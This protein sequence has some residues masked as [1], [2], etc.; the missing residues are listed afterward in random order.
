MQVFFSWVFREYIK[1][2]IR[3]EITE[4]LSSICLKNLLSMRDCLLAKLI[5]IIYLSLASIFQWNRLIHHCYFDDIQLYLSLLYWF[6]WGQ[7][8][9][10]GV[11][12]FTKCLW[13]NIPWMELLSIDFI[14]SS[15]IAPCVIYSHLLGAVKH[16]ATDTDQCYGKAVSKVHQNQ[17]NTIFWER[18]F[19]WFCLFFISK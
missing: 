5:P 13:T 8:T 19:P 10:W 3:P 16:L 15:I 7:Y 6:Y 12:R 18:T 1:K 4:K 9:S 14:S 17:I 11:F 2:K